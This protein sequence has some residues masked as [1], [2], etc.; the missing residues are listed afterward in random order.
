MQVLC[1]NGSMSGDRSDNT[2]HD[3]NKILVGGVPAIGVSENTIL[4]M[5]QDILGDAGSQEKRVLVK[6]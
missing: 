1:A 3:T 4:S 6:V 2:V 5:I